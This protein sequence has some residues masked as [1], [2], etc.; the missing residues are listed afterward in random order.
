MKFRLKGWGS[1]CRQSVKKNTILCISL[2]QEQ[3]H[4]VTIFSLQPPDSQL[5]WLDSSQRL[6][7]AAYFVFMSWK[8]KWSEMPFWVYNENPLKSLSSGFTVLRRY[9]FRIRFAHVLLL[10]LWPTDPKTGLTV[11]SSEVFREAE[12]NCCQ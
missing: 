10:N 5:K 2:L 1:C 7:F 3:H 9:G 6:W 4:I 8:G 12:V 11:V